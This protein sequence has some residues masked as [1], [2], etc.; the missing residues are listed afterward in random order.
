MTEELERKLQDLGMA[1]DDIKLLLY[2]DIEKDI[3]KLMKKWKYDKDRP[4]DV[5]NSL[6]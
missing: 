5:I 2:E 3:K 1:R 4:I 6:E